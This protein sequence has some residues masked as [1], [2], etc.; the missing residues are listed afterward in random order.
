MIEWGLLFHN[1]NRFTMNTV[2]P[3]DVVRDESWNSLN[4]IWL[5]AIDIARIA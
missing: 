2:T 5:A 1:P 3:I 4:E